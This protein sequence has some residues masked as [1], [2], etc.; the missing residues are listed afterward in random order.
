MLGDRNAASG[1]NKYKLEDTP[2]RYNQALTAFDGINIDSND[3]ITAN[4]EE[5]SG[6][7]TLPK[8]EEQPVKITHEI[9]LI[10]FKEFEQEYDEYPK[11]Q[12]QKREY[13]M[14]LQEAKQLGGASQDLKTAIM[15]TKSSLE[16]RQMEKIMHISDTS[17]KPKSTDLA[18]LDLSIVELKQNLDDNK[19]EYRQSVTKLKSLKQETDHLGRLVE[20]SKAKM[21]HDFEHWLV[22]IKFKGFD[23]LESNPTV[24]ETDLKKVDSHLPGLHELPE[25]KRTDSRSSSRASSQKKSL[26]AVAHKGIAGSNEDDV[27]EDIKAFFKASRR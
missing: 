1:N 18:I 20:S 9:R 14:K 2:E 4:V 26:K 3:I 15:N 6:E 13:K 8:I 17:A 25:T 11:M 27:E 10:A 24:V 23:L 21:I 12:S 5:R 22:N 19:Q 16:K 7:H